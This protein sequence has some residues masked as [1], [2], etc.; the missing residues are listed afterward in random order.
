MYFSAKI[1]P[2]DLR[3][4]ITNEGTFSTD[5]SLVS[6]DFM[7]KVDPEVQNLPVCAYGCVG[8]FLKVSGLFSPSAGRNFPPY[9]EVFYF[10][11]R[12]CISG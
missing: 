11:G 10:D 1:A 2:S 12:F 6:A 7:C 8:K 5:Q 9:R 3:A 4:F